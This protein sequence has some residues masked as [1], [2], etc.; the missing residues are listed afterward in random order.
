MCIGVEEK[1]MQSLSIFGDKKGELL[2]S[3]FCLHSYSSKIEVKIQTTSVFDMPGWGKF[4]KLL[5]L[6]SKCLTR[7]DLPEETRGREAGVGK[8]SKPAKLHNSHL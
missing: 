1:F 6:V 5:R 2:L 4:W 8:L 3:S 7:K